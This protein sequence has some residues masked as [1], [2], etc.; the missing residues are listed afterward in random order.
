MV[1]ASAQ[2]TRL[3]Y[4]RYLREPTTGELALLAL[5]GLAGLLVLTASGGVIGYRQANSARAF[6]A[7]SAA[8]FL[9]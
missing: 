7:Q 2:P 3:G 6:R 8:R 9:R 4:S 1:S 5:P